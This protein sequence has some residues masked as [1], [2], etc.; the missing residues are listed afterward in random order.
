MCISLL[1]HMPLISV[2]FIASVAHT[3]KVLNS[4]GDMGSLIVFLTLA[5]KY[6]GFLLKEDDI[7]IHICINIYI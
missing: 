3:P 4:R 5:R 1:I 2:S 7:Y 6:L